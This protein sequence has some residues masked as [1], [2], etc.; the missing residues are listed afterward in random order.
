MQQEGE[1]AESAEEA[2][3]FELGM[4]PQEAEP[5]H[6]HF[7]QG[8]PPQEAEPRQ[9]HFARGMPSQEAEPRRQQQWECGWPRHQCVLFGPV[10]TAPAT[11]RSSK[12]ALCVSLSLS[13]PLCVS[14]R[15]RTPESQQMLRDSGPAQSPRH[16]PF[17]RR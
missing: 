1:E 10:T 3:A 12:G 14:Q 17:G 4:P 5:R 16:S 7:A 11:L 9:Q 8:M 2:E 15:L 6:Q 13:L